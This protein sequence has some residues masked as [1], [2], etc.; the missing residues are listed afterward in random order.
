[1]TPITLTCC[2]FFAVWL[3]VTSITL[4]ALVNPEGRE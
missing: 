2:A 1:M 3:V 4:Y